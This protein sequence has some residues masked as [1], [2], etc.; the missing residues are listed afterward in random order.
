MLVWSFG[1][2]FTFFIKEARAEGGVDMIY[3]GGNNMPAMITSTSTA[4]AVIKFEI[5]DSNGGTLQSMGIQLNEDSGSGFD[6]SVALAP[7]VGSGAISGM[8]LWKDNGD[9][10]F[11]TSSDTYATTLGSWSGTGPWIATFSSIG[12]SIGLTYPTRTTIFLAFNADEFASGDEPY[13]FGVKMNIGSIDISGGSIVSWPTTTEYRGPIILGDEGGWGSPIVISE[14]MTA[15]SSPTNEFVELYNR[16][17]QTIDLN[18]WSVNY[19]PYN[20]AS[21]TNWIYEL[22]YFLTTTLMEPGSYYL[23]ARGDVGTSSDAT[24]SVVDMNTQGGFVGLLNPAEEIMDLVGYGTNYIDDTL[25]EGGQAAPTPYNHY[26]IERKAFDDS[27]TIMMKDGGVDQYMGNS[28]DS[29]NNAAD[30]IVRYSS[31]PQNSNSSPEIPEGS[32]SEGSSGGSAVLINEIYYKADSG[33]R[34][35]ELINRSTSTVY[36]DNYYIKH[37][38]GVYYTIPS[39][40]YSY[41]ASS[42]YKIIHWNQTGTNDAYNLY[43]GALSMDLDTLG[44]DLILKDFFGGEILDYVQYGSWGYANETEA[45]ND[46]QWTSGDYVSHCVWG[47]SIGRDTSYGQ[48]YNDSY[49]WQTYDT[50]SPGIPNM[51]GDTTAPMAVTNVTLTDNDDLSNSGIDG[52]DITV[53]WNPATTEE[54]NFDRYEIYVLASSTEIDWNSHKPIES[55]YDG[56]Y[57]YI[58]SVQQSTYT[59][60]GGSW[61]TKDSAGNIIS[62]SEYKAYVVLF[63]NAGNKSSVAIS[64]STMLNEEEYSASSDYNPPFIMHMGVWSAATGSNLHLVARADDDRAMS[65]TTPL[66]VTWK[67]GTDFSFYLHS[68]ASTT[69]CTFLQANFYDCVIGWNPAWDTNTVIGYYLKAEDA[70]E[71]PNETYMSSDLDADTSGNAAYHPFYI[72]FMSAPSDAGTDSDLSGYTFAWDGNALATTTVFFEGMAIAPVTSS[73]SGT[74]AFPDDIMDYGMY[75][76]MALKDGYM[77]MV[78]DVYRGNTVSFYLN[79]G[80]MNMSGGTGDGGANPI[81]TWTAP[82]DNMMGAPIDIFCTEDCSTMGDYEEP[83]IVA[84][85]RLMNGSTIND[86]NAADSGSNIYLTSNGNDRVSGKVYYDSNS[87][88]ARFFA[89]THDTLALGTYYSIVVTQG[90][91]DDMGN[92]INGCNSDGSFSNG[93]TTIMST[94]TDYTNY[95]TGGATMPPYVMGVT[96]APG[97]FNVP[98]NT[99]VIIEFSEPMDSS[100]INESNIRLILVTNSSM[101]EGSAVSATVSLDQTTRRIATINPDAD[102]SATS[103]WWVIKVLGNVKS[104]TGMFMANPDSVDGGCSDWTVCDELLAITAFQSNFQINTGAIDTTAPTVLGT[105]PNN[106]DGIISSTT[107]VYVGIGAIEIG[108]SEAM[109]PSTINAENIKLLAG[110]S[111][112]GGNVNYDPMSSNAKFMPSSALLANTQYTLR[113]AAN[114]TDL[115]D[116]QLNATTSK[117]FKTGAGDTQAPELM[118]ANGDD[119]SIAVTFNEPMNTAQ[120]TDASNWPYSVFNPANY[121]VNGLVMADDCKSWSCAVSEMPFY[122]AA[123]GTP[124]SGLGLSFSYDDYNNTVIIEGFQ[125]ASFTTDFQ[126]F[127]DNVRDKSNNEISDSGN[128]AGDGSYLNAARSPLYNSTDTYGALG[129]GATDYTMD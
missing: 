43:T 106:N 33:S 129:P 104:S 73:A 89:I 118:Y 31:E 29:N 87:R 128:R 109:D 51:G 58:N 70:A 65:S 96:P 7:L 11:S 1:T 111:V 105:Y 25:A 32:Y 10:V 8:S 90:V 18:G 6:P 98:R 123:T 127:A 37:K 88:E 48:D 92:P 94:T 66:S 50:P 9:G 53:S 49:D 97:S 114:C 124:L 61:I 116:N 72:D 40:G 59:Y 85:D 102:L 41:I 42:S 76:L 21:N 119:Y 77:N 28:E 12:W 83:I 4:T 5:Y 121:A 15:S 86:Q 13:A 79:E 55:L 2:P 60:A 69:N 34:W 14:I 35:I 75:H 24:Y 56:Q 44:G 27:T 52:N 71:T 39:S 126:I 120:Q 95:G 38:G 84:F 20:V 23:I 22:D 82:F 16:S 17:D 30:L 64:A 91:T 115:A 63:D 81:I 19:N 68:G 62:E 110:T 54:P 67:A 3:L 122:D 117:Y 93:F 108:F 36:I 99:S 103:T 101:M 46:Y 57:Q 112:T 26:S 125:F 100:S 78:N 80:D 47:Q 45:V 113:V 107:A 74:F